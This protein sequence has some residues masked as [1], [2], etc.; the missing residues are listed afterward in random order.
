MLAKCPG[1]MPLHP[2]RITVQCMLCLTPDATI[3]A[4]R[5]QGPNITHASR[6]QM[7][8]AHV[9]TYTSPLSRS[10]KVS[11]CRIEHQ[12]SPYKADSCMWHHQTLYPFTGFSTYSPFGWHIVF[13]FRVAYSAFVSAHSSFVSLIS[14]PHEP[15]WLPQR[16]VKGL[17]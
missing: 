13:L 2:L 5:I 16:G 14:W 3:R 17:F 6:A 12:L 11:M 15:A 1:F 8:V 7:I 4:L 10:D 9:C